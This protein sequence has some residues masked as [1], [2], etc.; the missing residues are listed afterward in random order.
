MR[1]GLLILFLTTLLPLQFAAAIKPPPDPCTT[2]QAEGQT[3]TSPTNTVPDSVT[4]QI[5]IC[6]TWLDYQ[7]ITTDS[8]CGQANQTVKSLTYTYQA[9]TVPDLPDPWGGACVPYV[10]QSSNK[11]WSENNVTINPHCKAYTT[12]VDKCYVTMSSENIAFSISDV[13]LD[14]TEPYFTVNMCVSSDITDNQTL[15]PEMC[16]DGQGGVSGYTVQNNITVGQSTC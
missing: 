8:L 13:T 2:G 9:Y 4:N 10:T 14:D 15:Q 1:R 11:S 16:P 7:W 5:C 12:P 3:R 6:K